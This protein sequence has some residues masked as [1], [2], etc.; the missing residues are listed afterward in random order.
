MFEIS[1][2][3]WLFR[4]PFF[5]FGQC[6][7]L[8]RLRSVAIVSSFSGP[9]CM[10]TN[11]CPF[12]V[13]L[14]AQSC[15]SGAGLPCAIRRVTT[16][17]CAIVLLARPGTDT[18]PNQGLHHARLGIRPPT[19]GQGR[20]KLASGQSFMQHRGRG[21]RPP[22]SSRCSGRGVCR[23]GRPAIGEEPGHWAHL[24]SDG[25][26]SA[27]QPVAGVAGRTNRRERCTRRMYE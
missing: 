7:A 14:E 26:N 16:S 4:F 24:H 3:W 11:S 17:S 25:Y 1:S 9:V 5:L 13:F 20:F 19:N 10:L 15:R 12:L 27:L 18:V 6:L 22:L 23:R 2:R 21:L 8:P